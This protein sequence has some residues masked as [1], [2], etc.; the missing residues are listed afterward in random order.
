M[1]EQKNV[2]DVFDGNWKEFVRFSD[3]QSPPG[4]TWSTKSVQIFFIKFPEYFNFLQ[5]TLTH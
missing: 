3:E 5:M 4:G 2:D 1:V